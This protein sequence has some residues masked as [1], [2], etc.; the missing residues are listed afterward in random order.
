MRIQFHRF[1]GFLFTL[2]SGFEFEPEDIDI[3][4]F[5]IVRVVYAS[6]DGHLGGQKF[7]LDPCGSAMGS[8]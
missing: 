7:R 2:N 5:K 6:S 3:S 4:K 8:W 1:L